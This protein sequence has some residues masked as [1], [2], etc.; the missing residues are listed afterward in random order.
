[1]EKK[2]KDHIDCGCKE[3][4]GWIPT[5]SKIQVNSDRSITI[6]SPSGWEYIGRVKRSSKVLRVSSGTTSVSCTCN[7]SGNCL[8][9]VGSG[10]GG[11]TS[12][13]A[14][15]CTNCT[16][17]QS[18]RV[19]NV[20]HNF[21]SGGYIDF[22]D[23]VRFIDDSLQL[24][25]AFP[26]MFELP[27]VEKAIK[28]FLER[29]YGGLPFP[30][31]KIGEN[32]VAAPTGY[33]IAPVS[34]F[35][36]VVAVAVPTIAIPDNVRVAQGLSGGGASKASCSCTD[37]TCTVKSVSVLIGSATYCEGACNG[38]CTLTMSVIIGGGDELEY[39]KAISYKF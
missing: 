5:N 15:S 27:E 25:A 8:P 11:N 35:G 4:S 19:G 3:E 26:E 39:Y 6:Q 20:N 2:H 36:R 9:F 31:M 22:A 17:T 33:T 38:T 10:P 7:T 1:M 14:G 32:F 24:P 29:V 16:M 28:E 37:G 30:K 18:A 21:L 34:L 23:T 12:G 13:C